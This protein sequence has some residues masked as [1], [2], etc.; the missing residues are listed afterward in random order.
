MP[1]ATHWIQ[2]TLGLRSKMVKFLKF[3]W[4]LI[5]PLMELLF[6]F[7]A[8]CALVGFPIAVLIGPPFAAMHFLIPLLIEE[9]Q[10]PPWWMIPLSIGVMIV[11]GLILIG[12]TVLV[13]DVQDRWGHRKNR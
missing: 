9:G 13:S 8:G 2:I 4:T 12:A 11:W 1:T 3:L 6:V 7:V 5:E 10:K